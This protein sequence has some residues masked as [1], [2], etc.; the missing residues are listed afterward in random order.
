MLPACCGSPPIVPPRPRVTLRANSAVDASRVPHR[1]EGRTAERCTFLYKITPFS[2]RSPGAPRAGLSTSHFRCRSLSPPPPQSRSGPARLPS[3]GVTTRRLAHRVGCRPNSECTT[4]RATRDGDLAK[5][6]ISTA[7]CDIGA[8]PKAK[9]GR[10]A[11]APTLRRPPFLPIPHALAGAQS[12]S[13][14]LT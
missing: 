7:Y 12:C 1:V 13:L 14:S 9:N 4:H 2:H 6:H 5:L 3:T 10:A 11:P 8:S